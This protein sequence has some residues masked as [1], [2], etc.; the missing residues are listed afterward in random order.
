MFA[1]TRF[2]Q[3]LVVHARSARR[4]TPL[5]NGRSIIQF[6]F[7]LYPLNR[8]FPF[9]ANSYFSVCWSLRQFYDYFIARHTRSSGPINSLFETGLGG[10]LLALHPPRT[11][12]E[13]Y[14]FFTIF[15][16]MESKFTDSLLSSWNTSERT[17]ACYPSTNRKD[18]IRRHTPSLVQNFGTGAK[19]G[20]P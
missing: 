12:P 13:T 10:E 14:L 11:L 9:L 2:N 6:D 1:T 19:A 17:L 7:F 15:V 8:R 5:S 20:Q 16:S 4:P 18:T 3:L